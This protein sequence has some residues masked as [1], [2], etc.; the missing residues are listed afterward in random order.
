MS[1]LRPLFDFVNGDVGITARPSSCGIARATGTISAKSIMISDRAVDVVASEPTVWVVG[2]L[3]G[4]ETEQE[5]LTLSPIAHN[6]R[7]ANSPSLLP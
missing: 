4:H 5:L 3:W 6:I 7:P 2:V 1:G